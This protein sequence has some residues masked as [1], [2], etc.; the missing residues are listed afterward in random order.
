MTAPA[1][2]SSTSGA[3][4]CAPSPDRSEPDLLALAS[5]DHRSDEHGLQQ[6]EHRSADVQIASAARKR[7]LSYMGGGFAEYVCMPETAL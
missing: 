1:W 4:C 2:H 5:A 3:M 7:A 6:R